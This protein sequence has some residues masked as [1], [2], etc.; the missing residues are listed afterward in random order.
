[1]STPVRPGSPSKG[2]SPTRS[3]GSGS[4]GAGSGADKVRRP[5]APGTVARQVAAEALQRIAQDGAYANL[6]LPTMLDRDDLEPRDRAFVTELVYGATRMRRS[7]DWLVDRFLHSD[8]DPQARAFLRLGAYQLVFLHTPAHAAVGA[9]VEA[10]PRKLR[11]L[12]NAV[13]RRV[14]E[15]A[16]DWPDE[17][18]RLSY[19]DWIIDRIV[20]DLGPHDGP[21]ALEAMNEPAAAGPRD[22]GYIQDLASR[23]V[24]DSV[25][26]EPGERVLDLCAAPGGKASGMATGGAT[27]IAADVRPARV[28][29]TAKNVSRLGMAERVV[30]IVADGVYPPFVP[31]SFDRILVDAPCSGLGA[32]RRRPDARWRIAPDD[33]DTLAA[34]QRELLHAAVPLLKPRGVLVYSVCTLTAAESEAID[35]HLSAT[36]PELEALPIPDDP[37]PTSPI[38]QRLWRPVGRGARLLPQAAATDGMYVLRLR[39]R[40]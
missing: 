40:T 13:L 17:A 16:H 39:S 38:P 7:C 30:P 11:G 27:V 24:A 36:C 4:A 21:A 8:L 22:D 34:L 1:M 12:V 20:T 6:L 18:T 37:V 5:P 10:A 29:L 19:P 32:L 14:S 15:A 3:N 25:G 2:P 28:A 9:T 23:W 35:E 26:A 33:V 31:G